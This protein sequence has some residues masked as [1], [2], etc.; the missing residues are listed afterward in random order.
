MDL[1][2]GLGLG[3]VHFNNYLISIV[4]KRIQKF[5]TDDVQRLVNWTERTHPNERINTSKRTMDTFRANFGDEIADLV[6]QV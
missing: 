3:P 4:F 1:G 6:S 5:K 2:P